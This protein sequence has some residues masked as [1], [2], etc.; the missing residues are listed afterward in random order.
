MNTF[1]KHPLLWILGC[2]FVIGTINVLTSRGLF[3]DEGVYFIVGKLFVFRGEN[4]NFENWLVGSPWSYPILVGLILKFLSWLG[5]E[6][7]QLTDLSIPVVREVNVLIFLGTIWLVYGITKE[8]SEN[9]KI[10]VWGAGI[11]A[12]TGCCLFTAGFATYDIPSLLF[13]ALSLYCILS[14]TREEKDKY[15]N[16][17]IALSGFLLA[18]SFITKYITVVFVPTM[19]A[20]VVVRNWPRIKSTLSG[21][22]IWLVFFIIPVGWYLSKVWEGVRLVFLYSGG[23]TARYGAAPESIILEILWFIGLPLFLGALATLVVPDKKW[24]LSLVILV[25]SLTTPVYHLVFRDPLALFKQMCWSVLLIAPIAAFFAEWLF[26]KNKRIFSL[27]VLAFVMIGGYQLWILK[28]FYPDPNPAITYLR[29]RLTPESDSI[30]VDDSWPYRWGLNDTFDKKEWFVTDQWWW[31]N[32][33]ADSKMWQDLINKGTFSYIV[34]EKGGAFNGEFTVFDQDVVKAIEQ[35]GRYEK[36]VEF[37]SFTSWG[38]AI[39]IPPFKGRLKAYNYVT[40]EI[41]ERR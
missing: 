16:T 11:F 12:F 20:I 6:G 7:I 5:F 26:N 30:L 3:F 4:W 14:G 19:L 17:F 10:A 36:V 15:K 24:F 21:L 31:Q 34:Y 38:N 35:S 23:H 28:Q 27:A 33:L 2:V 40:T 22:A 9:R 41:W 32:L 25:A 18:A 39:M 13:T 8:I 37:D 1:K 29:E